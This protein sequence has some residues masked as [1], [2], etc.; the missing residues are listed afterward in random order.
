MAFSRRHLLFAAPLT[1]IAH[2]VSAQNVQIERLSWAG[3]RLEIN[4]TT[5]FVDASSDASK[6]V[7]VPLTARTPRI[8]AVITHLHNDHFD[9]SALQT[10]LGPKGVVI[11]WSKIAA[12]VASL[13]FKVRSVDMYEP[14]TFGDTVL[15]PIPAVDGVGDAQVSWIITAGDRRFIHCGD[16]LWHGGF[17][18]IGK[19]YGPFDAAFLPINGFQLVDAKPPSGQPYDLTPEQA[20]AAAVL[21]RAKTLVP[22]HYGNNS[23]PDYIETP[24]AEPRLLAEAAKRNVTVRALKPGEMMSYEAGGNH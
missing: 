16:T 2:A 8:G 10:V 11:C 9:R 13:G 1:L 15:V 22:I 5:I 21:L 4:D 12:T 24:N 6:S 3:I 23:D 18:E 20:V 17:R 14:L 19:V 7:A